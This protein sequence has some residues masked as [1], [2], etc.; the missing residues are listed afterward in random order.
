MAAITTTGELRHVFAAM[1]KVTRLAVKLRY[2]D[3]L[4][5]AEIADVLDIT[6][7]GVREHLDAGVAAVR[8][9]VQQPVR[10]STHPAIGSPFCPGCH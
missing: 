9:A 10:R 1:P 3:D 5:V 4:S 7:A 6:E 2:A 8:K